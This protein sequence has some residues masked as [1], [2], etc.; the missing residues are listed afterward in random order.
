VLDIS[1]YIKVYDIESNFV[2]TSLTLKTKGKGTKINSFYL[3]TIF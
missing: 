3:V 2:D 1:L